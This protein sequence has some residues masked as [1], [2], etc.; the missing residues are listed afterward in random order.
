MSMLTARQLLDLYYLPMRQRILSLAADLDRLQGAADGP[1]IIKNDP[2]MLE[3]HLAIQILLETD[4][5][6][7]GRVQELLSDQTPPPP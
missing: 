1:E 5:G 2:R 7:A 6:R 3:L 4:T